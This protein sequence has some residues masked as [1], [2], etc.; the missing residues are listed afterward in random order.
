M[1]PQKIIETIKKNDD[2][3]IAAHVNPEGDAI[4]SQISLYLGL[5]KMHKKAYIYNHHPVPENLGFLPHVKLVNI[6]PPRQKPE[7]VIVLDCPNLS[8]V[9]KVADF[10]KDSF[11]INIDHHVS[12]TNF[13]RI[14][15]VR[16][17][18]SSA[19]EMI[20]NLVKKLKIKLDL[21]MARLI[22]TGIMT[23]T[24]SFRFEN[25]K[26]ATHRIVAEL[27]DCGVSPEVIYR[28]I[29]LDK[30]EEQ[31]KL[32][33]LVLDNM[34]IETN[35][36]IVY[37]FF[38]NEMLK[39]FK[40]K[41]DIAEDLIENIRQLHGSEVVILFRQL[42]N[43]RQVKVSL[44]SQGKTDVNKIAAMFGGGGHRAASGCLV[45]GSIDA[46]IKKV[47]AKAKECLS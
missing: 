15:W 3:L 43:N 30:T 4:A 6:K 1:I 26:G 35:G 37:S 45:S 19:S 47:I 39:S 18:A 46:V 2:F 25:T 24:G 36:K 22:Y 20:Y 10:I 42:E 32:I 29:F 44:R 34:K 38:T 27:L 40:A 7:V 41:P 17:D 12:N 33:R 28:Q 8:R 23:D 9:G 13:G 31:L 11:V 16:A 5:K 14:N 21:D